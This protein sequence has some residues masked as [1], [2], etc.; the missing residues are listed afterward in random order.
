METIYFD[1]DY[2]WFI[3]R[4]GYKVVPSDSKYAIKIEA[5]I[6]DVIRKFTQEL[7][8]SAL[9]AVEE[10]K[11]QYH[12]YHAVVDKCRDGSYWVYDCEYPE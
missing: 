2:E 7:T 1:K 11:V 10:F 4:E 9:R 3:E 12:P 5:D 8:D 6:G